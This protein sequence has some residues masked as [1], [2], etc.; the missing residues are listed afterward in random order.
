MI[1]EFC[2]ELYNAGE[3]PGVCIYSRKFRCDKPEC[4]EASKA[5]GAEME[6]NR[7]EVAV[8]EIRAALVRIEAKL[9]KL[10]ASTDKKSGC[11][12]CGNAFMLTMGD[13]PIGLARCPRCNFTLY[14]GQA[15]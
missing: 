13:D 10:C 15:S 8:K 12:R 1:C 7:P 14:P 9:D 6:A 4:I 2:G 3:D 11:P 5:F